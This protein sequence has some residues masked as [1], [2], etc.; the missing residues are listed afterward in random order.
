MEFCVT[1]KNTKEDYE[2]FH[3]NFIVSRKLFVYLSFILLVNLY[4]ISILALAT[5][6]FLQ[7]K[8]LTLCVVFTLTLAL[9]IFRTKLLTKKTSHWAEVNFT[10]Y[11]KDLPEMT[12]IFQEEKIMVK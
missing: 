8:S 3:Q 10:F 7:A 11:S 5:I 2:S 6:I 9:A 4:L 1:R 12:A